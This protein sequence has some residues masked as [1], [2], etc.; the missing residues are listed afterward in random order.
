MINNEFNLPNLLEKV[1]LNSTFL[2]L[3]FVITSISIFSKY[4]LGIKLGIL[5]LFFGGIFRVL[6]IIGSTFP[7]FRKEKKNLKFFFLGIIKFSLY[8][9]PLLIYFY[10][11]NNL[12]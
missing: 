5:T 3:G 6:N 7:N 2:V 11:A 8:L 1:Y 12:F 9:I 4:E 10:L